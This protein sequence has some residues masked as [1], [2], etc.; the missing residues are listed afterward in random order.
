MDCIPALGTIL[1][2][3]LIDEDAKRLLRNFVGGD[4]MRLRRLKKSL[5]AYF[6]PLIGIYSGSTLL[7]LSIYLHIYL[8]ISLHIYS[9]N[10][11]V[12][13]TVFLSFRLI[14]YNI[15]L[16]ICP[17]IFPSQLYLSDINAFIQLISISSLSLSIHIHL[18]AY[19]L[20]VIPCFYLIQQFLSSISPSSQ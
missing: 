17:T 12:Y 19:L 3:M 20:S 8:S 9:S 4:V 18:S 15:Y 14:A 16:S 5:G 13:S 11:S 7:C 6:N 1:Q 2:R 10:L